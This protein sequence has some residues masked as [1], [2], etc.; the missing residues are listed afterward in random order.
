MTCWLRNGS[1]SARSVASSRAHW[2]WKRADKRIGSSLEAAPVLH[3]AES[4][5]RTAL[6]GIDFAEICITSGIRVEAGEG[7]GSAFRLPDVKGVAVEPALASGVKCARSWRYFDRR[8]QTR[9]FR[10]LRR[11]MPR[12][13][14]NGG[15]P[16]GRGMTQARRNS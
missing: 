4:A 14:V 3:L 5:D 16:I 15:Q 10:T 8:R 12:P 9:R 2:S 6:D 1:V 7:P 13:C 11:G